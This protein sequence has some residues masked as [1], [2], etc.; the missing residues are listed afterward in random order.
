MRHYNFHIALLSSQPFCTR[1]L[2]ASRGAFSYWER[3][4][5][6]QAGQK[7]KALPGPTDQSTPGK[8]RTYQKTTSTKHYRYWF[9]RDVPRSPCA[10][11]PNSV[12][13]SGHSQEPW[14]L[15]DT[16]RQNQKTKPRFS[17]EQHGISATAI[18]GCHLQSC[19]WAAST[20]KDSF[21]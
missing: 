1:H 6:L 4:S 17:S 15:T 18:T 10:I 3:E 2:M 21:S 14:T 7:Q 11:T 20:V 13:G 9:S 12:I 16:Q 19:D 8:N 5:T